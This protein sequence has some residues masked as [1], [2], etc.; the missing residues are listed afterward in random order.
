VRKRETLI[1]KLGVTGGI[2]M[3]GIMLTIKLALF[4]GF[5]VF[6]IAVTAGTAIMGLYQIVR[7]RTRESRVLTSVEAFKS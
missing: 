6:V 2:E 3:E 4:Y 5:E 7:D 1:V